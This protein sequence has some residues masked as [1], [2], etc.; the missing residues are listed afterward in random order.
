[1]SIVY[2]LGAGA[3]HGEQLVPINRALPS[4]TCPPPVTTGF[5]SRKLLADTRY[6]ADLIE[7]NFKNLVNWIR[8][9][10]IG[11]GKV[12]IGEGQWES[13]NIED[14]FT[15]LEIRR[16]FESSESHSAAMLLLMKTELLSYIFR[17]IGL[18]TKNSRGTYSTA[19]VKALRAD[20]SII[21]FNWDLLIDDCFLSQ[22]R[23]NVPPQHYANF[24]KR[25]GDLTEHDAVVPGGQPGSGLFLKLH[26]SLNWFQCTNPRC[27]A[28]ERLI[29][30][31]DIDRCL[32][33]SMGIN[34]FFMCQR[35][36][37]ETLPMIVPPVLRKPIIDHETT[38]AAWGL[39]R[40]IVSSADVLVIIGFSAAPSDYYATWLFREAAADPSGG[41]RQAMGAPALRVIV[42]NPLNDLKHAA[43]AEFKQRM[44]KLFPLG[45]SDEYRTFAEIEEVSKRALELESG[46]NRAV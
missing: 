29:I 5:F 41:L 32:E 23:P 20:D 46:G 13:L 17:M 44:Q 30:R 39:A 15:W 21:T 8:W 37:S 6:S 43:H 45:Y 19:L 34:K 1:M 28:S 40:K 14:V 35:C 33:W 22:L 27:A 10:H 9:L 24:R 18:C 16:E 31:D 42:V 4:S 2:V 25:I 12:T 3:S 36:G 38:R 26:G 7:N 11:D